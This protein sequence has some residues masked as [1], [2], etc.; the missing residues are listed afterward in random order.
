[1]MNAL[2]INVNFKK[3]EG[4]SEIRIWKRLTSIQK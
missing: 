2:E 3:H 1:M 4:G